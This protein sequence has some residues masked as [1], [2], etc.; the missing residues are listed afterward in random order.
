MQAGMQGNVILSDGPVPLFSSALFLKIE[1]LSGLRHPMP[2]GC[3]I[4]LQTIAVY[5][6][7]TG[8]ELQ[9]GQVSLRFTSCCKWLSQAASDM[10][11]YSLCAVQHTS[12]AGLRRSDFTGDAQPLLQKDPVRSPTAPSAHGKHPSTA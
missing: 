10:S 2:A 5:A 7:R 11:W 3:K 9:T 6:M 8:Q 1:V 12:S 4:L